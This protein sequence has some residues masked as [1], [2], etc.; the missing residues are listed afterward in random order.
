MGRTAVIA[1]CRACR[2]LC[3]TS[4]P[5]VWVDTDVASHENADS[6]IDA[7]RSVF[8]DW[9]PE[10]MLASNGFPCDERMFTLTG[11]APGTTTLLEF[12]KRQRILDTALDAM[13]VDR[14]DSAAMFHLSRQA[15]LVGKVAFVLSGERVLGGVMRVTLVGSGISDWLRQVTWHPGRGDVPRAVDDDLA[16]TGTGESMEWFD[17][18][19]RPT[20]RHIDDD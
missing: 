16:M 20:M 7:V 15:A 13:S 9:Q 3:M 14:G 1:I 8:P 12:C 19:G 2:R 11:K 18:K 6:A 10:S 5:E 4:E 17:E